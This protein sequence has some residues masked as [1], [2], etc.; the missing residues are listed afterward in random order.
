MVKVFENSQIN[1]ENNERIFLPIDIPLTAG[2]NIISYPAQQTQNIESILEPIIFNGNLFSVFDEGGNVYIPGVI[3]SINSLNPGEAYYVKVNSDDILPV[4][5]GDGVFDD[6]IVDVPLYRTE[7][8]EPIWT[9]NPFSPMTF[10][11]S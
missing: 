11:V 3:N 5:E 7:H 1:L 4:N 2:W 9:G 10:S 6:M 8:F